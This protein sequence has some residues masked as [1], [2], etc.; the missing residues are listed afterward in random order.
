LAGIAL[1]YSTRLLDQRVAQSKD[2]AFAKRVD[3]VR[4]AVA[5]EVR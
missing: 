5:Q 4:D 3:S 1:Y 2:L